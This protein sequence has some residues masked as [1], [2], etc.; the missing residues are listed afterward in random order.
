MLRV[1]VTPTAEWKLRSG[2]PWVFSESI[3]AQNRDGH[4]GELAAIYDRHDN[5]LGIGLFDPSSPL[6][7]RVLHRGK[8]RTV[9]E[10]FW[11]GQL[12]AAIERRATLF[13]DGT[14]GYR[15]I[16][17]ENDAW[18]GLVLDRYGTTLVLKIY[19]AI[20]FPRLKEVTALIADE[21][22]PARVILRLSR[23]LQETTRGT[24]F[25]DGELLIGA[26]LDGP[27]VF[28]EN[29][30][31][32]EADVAR[33][34]KT[35]F[36][37]DQRDNRR[38]VETLA[39]GRDVLNLF[40]FSGGFS[41][42]AARG[43]ANSVTDVDISEHALE[44]GKRNFE[45]NAHLATVAACKREGMKADAFEWLQSAE[46][47]QFGLIIVDPPSLAKRESERERGLHAYGALAERA[48]AR[49]LRGGVLVAS[50][51]SSHVSAEEFFS[52]LREAARQ[53]GR[54][55]KELR[56]TGHPLDHPA[57]FSEAHYLKTIYLGF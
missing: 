51:C 17:G 8:P 23:N 31:S 28:K 42:Y 19:S 44:S 24:R 29:G 55:Y 22:K 1:H 45:R 41:L 52:V 32:F 53:S 12:R 2:H 49:L 34:Q 15:V 9:D 14:D 40:A 7:I 18:P 13:D 27:V 26:P 11:R 4:T 35:G 30:L 6:R 46:N 20:W 48:M 38:A 3:T 37:L 10:A 33:G 16:H 47:R 25:Q 5:F 39:D 43:G 36:F 57:A 54:S 50:S 21:L 56:T